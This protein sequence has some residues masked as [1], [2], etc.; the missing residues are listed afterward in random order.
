[1]DRMDKINQM[2]KREIS[3]MILLG[4]IRDP[5]IQMVT[6]SY[7][8]VSKD[9]SWAHV[10]FS[11]LSDKPEDIK[12]VQQGLNSASGAVRRLLA[13]RITLRHVP[14]VKFVYDDTI[15]RSVHLT[16]V[17]D[18]LSKDRVARGIDPAPE[19]PVSDEG[20]V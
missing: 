8:D 11:V 7:V 13:Q 20:A 4:E 2:C 17:F 14:Q 9:L 16:Q 15:S 18:D 12:N 19:S 5:R 6:I 3:A 10:G 1:M